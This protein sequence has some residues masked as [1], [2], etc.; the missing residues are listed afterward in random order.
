[1]LQGIQGLQG[2]PGTPGT[3]GGRGATGAT[4]DRGLIGPAG[5]TGAAGDAPV[6]PP[7]PYQFRDTN[8]NQLIGTFSLKLEDE[9]ET[10]R[11][12]S[13][14]GCTP[15]SFGSLPSPCYFT[16]RGLPDTLERWLNDTLAR[17]PHAVQD[18]TVRGPFSSLG[19]GTPD[20]QFKLD[21][22]FITSADLDLD[23]LS[24]TLGSVDLVVAANGLHKQTPT[25]APACDCSNASQT[26]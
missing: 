7:T 23:S 18:I 5:P 26:N 1:G 6:T 9:S 20:V 2:D 10:I 8:L 3:P 4:G 12:T 19:G 14:A 15:P 13:F 22:A 17:N 16:I 11:V 24:N 25:S 21:D